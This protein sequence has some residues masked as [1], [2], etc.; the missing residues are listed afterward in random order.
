M[1]LQMMSEPTIRNPQPAIGPAVARTSEVAVVDALEEQ[2]GCYRK[3]AKLAKQQ[4]EHVQ[5][6]QTELLMEVLVSRQVMLEQIGR[7]ERIV[8]SAKRGWSEFVVSLPPDRRAA[9]EMLLAETRTLLEEITN[10]DRNDVLVLQQRKLNVGKEIG[11]ATAARQ[12]NRQYAA[13]AY[14]PGKSR[15]DVQR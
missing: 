8:S 1:G 14:G 7:L 13:S 6:N 2:L 5:Q 4:H 10:S 12:L 3:L 15:M 11:Q 9:A